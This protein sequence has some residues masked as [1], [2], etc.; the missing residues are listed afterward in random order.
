MSA[1]GIPDGAIE[2]IQYTREIFATKMSIQR[3]V[4]ET[5]L[6]KA[7]STEFKDQ[8]INSYSNKFRKLFEKKML[9]E[10]FLEKAKSNL[11]A[12]IEEFVIELRMVE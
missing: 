6:G 12:T 4:I 7:S 1:E 11:E 8:W 9:D 10:S 3:G 5:F 2:P